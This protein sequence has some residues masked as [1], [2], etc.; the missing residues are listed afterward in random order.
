AVKDGVAKVK[1]FDE[2]AYFESLK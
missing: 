2:K 1:N